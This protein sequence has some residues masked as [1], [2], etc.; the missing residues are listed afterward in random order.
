MNN[1]SLKFFTGSVL[2]S[3]LIFTGCGGENPRNSEDVSTLNPHK[4]NLRTTGGTNSSWHGDVSMSANYTD[5]NFAINVLFDQGITSDVKHIHLYIDVDDNPNTGFSYGNISGADYLIEDGHLFSSTSNSDWGWQWEEEL[6]YQKNYVG[7]NGYQLNVSRITSI[8]EVN[9]ADK[10]NI[11]IGAVN[12]QWSP[13][14]DFTPL[15]SVYIN[16]D[17]GYTPDPV[18]TPDPVEPVQYGTIY[19]DAE[20][21]IGDWWRASGQHT[22]TSGTLA[23]GNSYV[24]L[25]TDWLQT[26]ADSWINR[27]E[28]HLLIENY[29]DTILSVDIVGD[30]IPMHHYILGVDVRTSYGNRRLMWDSFYNHEGMPAERFNDANGLVSMIF[31]SPVELVRGYD[32]SDVNLQE[33]FRVDLEAALRQ[34]EPNNEILSIV[35]FFATGGNLDN[36][37]LSN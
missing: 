34:F 30:G 25:G 7:N 35:T 32:F 36:I 13:V 11:S 4:I 17:G 23:N 31:P 37:R 21:G 2:L 15:Q 6:D 27:A 20:N 28:Y 33:T 29:E 5:G 26:G 9:N 24:K 10:L 22:P 14:G 3:A 18:V 12:S 8:L 19:E 1:I 16:F